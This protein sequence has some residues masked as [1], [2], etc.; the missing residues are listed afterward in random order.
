MYYHGWSDPWGP[1]HIG[2]ATSPDGT[3]WTKYPYPVIYASGGQE[4]Q[5]APSSIIKIEDTYYLYYSGRNLPYADI[6]LAA[7]PDGIN[8]TKYSGNPILTYDQT[9]EGTGVYYPTVYK[10]NTEYVMVFMNSTGTGFGSAT[11]P[12]GMNWTKDQS[13]PFFTKE[14][15]HNYWADY[16]I[17]YPHFLRV[18]NHDRIYYTG[19]S[20][21]G[22]YKIGFVSK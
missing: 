15:T 13:N 1:W 8:W 4:Y 21:Y 7:S 18:D 12:D 14:Q 22:P 2:L 11:S 3:N 20:N 9:W 17:A 19:F 6:R 5:I 16:K 10:K